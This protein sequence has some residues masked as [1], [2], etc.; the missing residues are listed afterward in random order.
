MTRHATRCYRDP[1]A[2]HPSTR[3]AYNF[4]MEL[5]REA[6]AL[7]LDFFSMTNGLSLVI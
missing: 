6:L 7:P 2:Y 1:G 4:A 3:Q 5:K